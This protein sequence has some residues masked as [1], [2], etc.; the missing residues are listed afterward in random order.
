MKMKKW[1]TTG[2][3]TASLLALAACGESS[4][5]SEENDGTKTVGVLQLVEHGSLNAAYEGF[6]EGLA[7]AGYTEGEN[8]TIEYQNAQNSQDNLKSMSERLVNASPDLLLGIATPAAVSLANETTDTPIVVT[9]V[10]DLV[11]AKLADS[12]EEPGRNITGTS[13]MVPIEQQINLLLS[14]VPDAKTI[15]IMYNAGEAN[16]KIQ[17]DLAEEALKAAGVDVKVLTAN[18]TNDVQQVTTSLAKDVDGIYVPTDNTF[19]SAA[20]I[21]GEVAKETKTPIVA[22]SVEQVDDGALATYGID[23]K[24]L[25]IQTGKLAAKILDGDAEPATTPVETADNL[26]L[27]V[28][29][30]MAAA[31]G[32]DPASITAPE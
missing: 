4:N 6:K 26:E 9:A 22:G 10:T 28:N 21:V 14:I 23:Y 29:E 31:L 17:A 12:N 20:A 16:S 19:A 18:T 24:S 13:D 7:E 1:I 32:I 8:L 25:G 3:L 30:E 2:L 15:G 5:T 11:G 27:V